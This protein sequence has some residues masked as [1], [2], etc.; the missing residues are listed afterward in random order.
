MALKVS[1]RPRPRKSFDVFV[2]TVLVPCGRIKRHGG[3]GELPVMQH[4]GCEH[5][6]NANIRTTAVSKNIVVST[7]I[8]SPS[9]TNYRSSI[10]VSVHT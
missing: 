2:Y 4:L 6:Y 3:R 5:T 1:Q 7:L 9:L 10:T 8:Q